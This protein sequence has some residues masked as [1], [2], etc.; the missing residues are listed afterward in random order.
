MR[1][2]SCLKTAVESGP[3]LE[4]AMARILAGMGWSG[5]CAQG[6]V[7]EAER[8]C[9]SPC[10]GPDMAPREG[11]RCGGEP[12]VREIHQGDLIA[13]GLIGPYGKVKHPGE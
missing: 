10:T 11:G 12:A 5:A 2:N 13:L 3:A 1:G 4:T 8:E 6:I 9:Q 7:T